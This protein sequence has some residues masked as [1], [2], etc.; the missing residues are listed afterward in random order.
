MELVV[1][2]LKWL[3]VVAL[4][5]TGVAALVAAVSFVAAA[6]AGLNVV[7]GVETYAMWPMGQILGIL[8]PTGVGN[9]DAGSVG[10]QLIHLSLLLPAFWVGQWMWKAVKYVLST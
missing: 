4:V 1:Q 2:A 8:N 9:N 5:G 3:V 6:L 7:Q 10:Y